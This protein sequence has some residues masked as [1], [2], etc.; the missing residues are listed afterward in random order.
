MKTRK[1][2]K[3]DKEGKKQ[4]VVIWTRT[5]QITRTTPTTSTEQQL[6]NALDN[7]RTFYLR[8]NHKT[9][10]PEEIDFPGAG[11]ECF[12]MLGMFTEC[13]NVLKGIGL[14]DVSVVFVI[15]LFTVNEIG[16]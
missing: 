16:K 10:L 8:P 6:N 9:F 13:L 5:N 3:K 1:R 11:T 14:R 7:S 2:D 12:R 4:S 15:S